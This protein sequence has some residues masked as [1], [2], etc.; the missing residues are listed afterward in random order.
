MFQ[1]TKR[2]EDEENIGDSEARI[3][4]IDYNGRVSSVEIT[5]EYEIG[6]AR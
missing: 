3:E 6:F 5:S 1:M 4:R 2:E